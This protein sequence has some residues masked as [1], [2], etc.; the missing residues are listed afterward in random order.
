MGHHICLCHA[1]LMGNLRK[2][3]F[4]CRKP[5]PPRFCRLACPRFSRSL[6][7][8]NAG[9]VLH[10]SHQ[11]RRALWSSRRPRRRSTRQWRESR[12]ACLA[13]LRG[14]ASP[15][16][17]APGH[18]HAPRLCCAWAV[19]LLRLDQFLSFYSPNLPSP[20]S[21]RSLYKPLETRTD[22]SI[23][24][25]DPLLRAILGA[26]SEVQACPSLTIKRWR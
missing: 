4:S 7:F 25:C 2:C 12:I 15:H 6:T 16:A 17:C 11:K 26:T 1:M 19:I 21:T 3:N 20:S 9:N 8:Q 22:R 13:V 18:E 23:D 24:Y 10:F 14:I 5:W